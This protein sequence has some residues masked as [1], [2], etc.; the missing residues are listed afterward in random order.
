MAG[1]YSLRYRTLYGELGH[2]QSHFSL[3][4]IMRD[5][6]FY[7]SQYHNLVVTDDSSGDIIYERSHLPVFPIIKKEPQ[8]KVDWLKEGF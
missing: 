1:P 5:F 2:V 7:F 8:Q 6:E 3:S 4:E